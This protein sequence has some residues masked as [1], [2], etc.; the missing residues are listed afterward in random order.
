MYDLQGIED[1]YVDLE[2]MS[3]EELTGANLAAIAQNRSKAVKRI[4]PALQR[5]AQKAGRSPQ[6]TTSPVGD[7]ER[8]MFMNYLTKIEDNDLVQRIK[9]GSARVVR[10][11]LYTSELV[12]GKT[13]QDL[14]STARTKVAGS[15]NMNNA[16]LDKDNV[17]LVTGLQLLSGIGADATPEAGRAVEYAIPSAAILNGQFT[18]KVG[19]ETFIERCSNR[20]FDS[21]SNERKG[22]HTLDTP[23][24][25]NTNRDFSFNC[26]FGVAP[27]ANT[28]AGL[29]VW[30][31]M[32]VKK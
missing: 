21:A 1:G 9:S 32:T 3:I 26:E 16:Q 27:V 14:F 10:F 6:M 4:A 11:V 25:T 12:G 18:F 8:A 23:I 29:Y 15:S 22:Y 24:L 20:V 2:Q 13:S 19:T 28:F 31:L 5:K 17:F 7:K 30:G